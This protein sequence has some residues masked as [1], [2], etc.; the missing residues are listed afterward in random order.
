MIE[1]KGRTKTAVVEAEPGLS[2]LQLALKHK[3]DWS[4]SC[5][6]GTCARCRCLITEGADGL[7]GITDA[8]WDRM[9]PEEFEEGYRLACQSI[10]KSE[11][12][13]IKAVNKPYF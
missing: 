12:V 5:T 10:I 7:E 8:E 4:S 11:A 1:L 3:V 13:A 2:L 6:R 9:D